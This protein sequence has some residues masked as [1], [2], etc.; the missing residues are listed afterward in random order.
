[1][2]SYT[3]QIGYKNSGLHMV[4]TSERQRFSWE[5][6]VARQVQ[7]RLFPSEQPMYPGLDFCSSWRAAYGV[8]G[9]YLDYFEIPGGSFGFAIGDVAGKGVSAALLMSSLHSAVR[10]LGMSSQSS[11]SELAAAINRHFL[12][13]TPENCFASLF[14]ARYDPSRRRLRFLNA[15]HEPPFVLRQTGSKLS[16]IDLFPGGPVVG[17]FKDA[18]YEEE[19]LQLMTGDLLAAYTD[20]VP[21]VR[22]PL[23]KEWGRQGLL[24]SITAHNDLSA[25]GIVRRA[26]AD[27]DAFAGGEP[28]LDDTTLWVG[29]VA[30]PEKSMPVEEAGEREEFAAFAA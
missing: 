30:D 23:G 19:S 29:R 16:T 3:T 15:G 10:M 17:M 27:M 26:M 1:M 18:V 14:L 28:Q 4:G 24:A 22:N 25:Q 21:D 8:S 13:V 6:D 12:R 20:G 5:L 2:T 7:A 11:L 9:D